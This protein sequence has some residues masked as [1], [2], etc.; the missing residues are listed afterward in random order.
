MKI[1][2]KEQ[3][4]AHPL[5]KALAMSLSALMTGFVFSATASYASDIEIYQQARSGNI[6]LMFVLD[7]SGSM[8]YHDANNIEYTSCSSS[9]RRTE[10]FSENGISYTKVGCRRESRTYYFK[11]VL[12]SGN[13][14]Y[15]SCGIDGSV[16]IS[17]CT[18]QTT[19]TSAPSGYSTQDI[20]G[21]IFYY[22][23][24]GNAVFWD[25]LTL[26]KDA[27]YQLLYGANAIGKDKFLGL[28]TYSINGDGTRGQVRI[29]VQRLGLDTETTLASE[30]HRKSLMT[31]VANLEANGGTPTANA[32]AE[33]A[34][35]MLGTSTS[36]RNRYAYYN[37]YWYECSGLTGST[38]NYNGNR[39][40]SVA[41]TYGAQSCNLVASNG[42]F[43][44]TCYYSA[45]NSASG[46][47]AAG[48][49]VLATDYSKYKMPTS[50]SAQLEPDAETKQCSGQGIYVLTD[51]VPNGNNSAQSLMQTALAGSSAFTCSDSSGGWDCV[52]KFSTRILNQ[53]TNANPRDLKLKTAV[54]GFGSAY[55]SIPSYNKN[56]S[57]EENIALL[58]TVNDDNNEKRAA[59]WGIRGQGGWYAGTSSQDVIDSVNDFINNLSTE[60]PA[61]TT[62]TSTIP[63]D[64]LNPAALQNYA[65]YPQFQPTPDKSYQLWAGNLK[66]YKVT[67][68]GT[69]VDKN[70]DIFVN[71]Q[72]KIGD[73]YDL[74]SADPVTG[75][76][77][78]DESILG[79]NKN[80]LVGGVKS[81]LKLRSNTNGAIQRKILTDRPATATNNE[82]LDATTLRALDLTLVNSTDPARGYL[83]S[84]LGYRVNAKEPQTITNTSIAQ[85][86]ELRQ[87]GAVM[88]SSPLLLTNQGKVTYENGVIG[89]EER[90]DYILFGTTQGVL[91]IV[92]ADTGEEKFAFLPNS[93]V[94]NQ[95]DALLNFD[96]TIGGMD[97]L[98]YGVDGPWTSYTEYVNAADD[99]LTVGAGLNSRS[100]KQIVYGGLR[101]G[102]RNYYALDLADINNPKLKF[103]ITPP[104]LSQ[105]SSA[106]PLACMGQSWSKPTLTWINWKGT[107][108]LVMLVG[109]GYDAEGLPT[110]ITSMPE[111]TAAERAAKQAKIKY[112]RGYEYNDYAQTNKI[113][114]GVYM[115]DAL[116]GSL[117]WWA[118]A[119]A[120]VHTSP[121]TANPGPT[122]APTTGIASSYDVDMKY[123]VVS[124]I[125]AV[126]RDSDGLTDHLYFGDLGGQVWRIDLNNKAGTNTALFAKQPTRVLNLNNGIYSPRFY[127]MPSFS[128]Y[129]EGG[130][131]FGVVSIGSGNR[132]QPLAEY[133]TSTNYK[134]DGVFNLYDKDVARSDLF[135]LTSSNA[136]VVTATGTAP[137][138]LNTLGVTLLNES[139]NVGNTLIN[140][141]VALDNTN[142]FAITSY[143]A[144][145]DLTQGWYY[146][147]KSTLVQSEKVMSTPL[148]INNDMFVTTFDGSRNGMSGDC[149]AGVKGESF[150]TLFCMPYGQCN[151]G[152][153]TS[154][155]LS[156]GAGIVGG[157]VGA[158]DGSGMQRLI[159]ANVDT[160]GVT[161]NAILDKRYNT[162]NKLIPQRWYDRR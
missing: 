1:R 117:L 161:G 90:D 15:L 87:V 29:P 91:H 24:S 83:L 22:S 12:V 94:E 112:Y 51:G 32:Y 146:L 16:N 123:S 153:S 57:E 129:S 67:S 23:S 93:M 61:V 7:I 18:L 154:Y 155:R 43:S 84:L 160:S 109:G 36:N 26:V 142:R 119:N 133:S 58:G 27:M 49:G 75:V 122:Y 126:D 77:Q 127:E 92:D 95:K 107:K 56:L 9:N 157:A 30:T 131:I 25:R 144:P 111:T 66:K 48:S 125:K 39:Y 69:L 104:A 121:T 45:T 162:G 8:D 81:R 42:S 13:W 99:M 34:A 118:S 54:V 134:H 145:Y 68:T 152:T 143:R 70:D 10:S 139:S 147:F 72:G 65:Y 74:W 105:C 2:K 148:V 151:G 108:K 50:L 71:S 96:T 38:C 156:M 149:G 137:N 46:Q 124:Q 53:T 11:R 102:G 37:S 33:A 79:S 150:M 5:K 103:T 116:D 78:D 86:E 17:D 82:Y 130:T 62:G 141:L 4:I 115:F 59:R 113:G 31:E 40:S 132:S 47:Y 88:H 158:G 136:Y 6:S 128:T 98:Y 41:R 138:K 63:N 97:K 140:Q 55:N 80:R 100:G 35:Y 73:N 52:E 21:N 28:T 20:S 44:A 14:R 159:V 76:N 89:S 135:N 64:Q 110:S 85:A 60:I 114:S 3:L 106:N 19:R 101:M 120:T